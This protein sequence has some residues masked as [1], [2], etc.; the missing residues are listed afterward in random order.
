MASNAVTDR[1]CRR[2][3]LR[4]QGSKKEFE[5]VEMVLYGSHI[6]VADVSAFASARL[7]ADSFDAYQGMSGNMCVYVYMAGKI[8]TR[9]KVIICTIICA[10]AVCVNTLIHS[11]KTSKITTNST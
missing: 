4:E 7:A 5:T 1:K 10:D 9:Y 11:A 6:V 3:T 8:I 2:A